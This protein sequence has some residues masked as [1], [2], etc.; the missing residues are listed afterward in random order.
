ME[1]IVLKKISNRVCK[2]CAGAQSCLTLCNLMD[3]SPPAPLSI[4][5]SRQEYWNGLPFPP[6]G[7]LPDPGIEPV[8]PVFSALAHGFFTSESPRKSM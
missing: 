4:G 2:V 1:H 3:C 7:D 6:Q 5:L 8:S